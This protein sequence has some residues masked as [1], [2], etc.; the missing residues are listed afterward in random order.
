MTRRRLLARS[1]WARHSAPR[2]ATAA[3]AAAALAG[4][5][6]YVP[7]QQAPARPAPPLDFEL[8]DAGRQVLADQIGP[9]SAHVE[10][11][12][13]Q[14]TDGAFMVSVS[15]VVTTRG[16]V[17][18]WNGERVALP[19]QYVRQVRERRFSARRTVVAA[20]AAV[21]PF[22]AFVVTRN[23]LVGGAGET[24]QKPGSGEGNIQ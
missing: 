6:T 15:Q 18:H 16:Q 24:D 1:C 13:L 23:F 19:Q 4:C 8:D 11:R 22:L 17:F 2:A 20:A 21:T 5:Y 7:L 12:L 14:T 10:G 9:E 3:L